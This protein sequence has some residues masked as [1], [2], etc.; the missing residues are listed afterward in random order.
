MKTS[1]LAS[2]SAATTGAGRGQSR[3][4]QPLQARREGKD[5][6]DEGRTRQTDGL[7]PGRGASLRRAQ[8]SQVVGGRASSRGGRHESEQ[9]NGETDWLVPVLALMVVA[10]RGQGRVG[11]R[12]GGEERMTEGRGTL[13]S[14]AGRRKR[15]LTEVNLPSR[16]EVSP[17]PA[18]ARRPPDRPHEPQPCPGPP[19]FT[20]PHHTTPPCPLP[21]LSHEVRPVPRVHL[22]QD[23]GLQA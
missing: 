19:S 6:D 21:L 15:Q 13:D 14:W 1:R 22:A 5:E 7:G 16:I 11:C 23:V 10:G 3:S 20:T 4:G 12:G 9:R 18:C 17:R 2:E 8:V